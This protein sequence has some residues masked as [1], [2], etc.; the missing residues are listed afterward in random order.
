M[1]VTLTLI[2]VHSVQAAE[3][4]N[5]QLVEQEQ[6]LLVALAAMALHHLFLAHQLLTQAAVV[7]VRLQLFH[8]QLAEQVE[9]VMAE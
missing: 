8:L 4:V 6:T 1:V 3:A 2:A 5:Q 9:A 7:V